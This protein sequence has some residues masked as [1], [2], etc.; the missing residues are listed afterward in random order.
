MKND[1]WFSRNGIKITKESIADKKL[2]HYKEFENIETV[3]KSEGESN[4][5]W[6]D[7]RK[8]SPLGF[9]YIQ[10]IKQ[11]DLKNKARCVWFKTYQAFMNGN[12]YTLTYPFKYS[13]NAM[14]QDIN[15]ESRPWDIDPRCG[16]F[17]DNMV[18]VLYR[19]ACK[20]VDVLYELKDYKGVQEAMKTIMVD[21]FGYEDGP[22]VQ[23]N[24]LKI[25]SHGFDL[26]ESFRKRKES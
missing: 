19:E 15:I 12:A 21:L 25:L 17:P 5:E 3:D 2:K 16:A 22:K 8:E 11:D 26:K 20:F 10:R 23:T 1:T 4:S 18:D 24:T 7:V 9:W 6:V 13:D 14:S